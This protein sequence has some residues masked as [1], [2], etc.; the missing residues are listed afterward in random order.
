M[1]LGTQAHSDLI[2]M[3][4][5]GDWATHD[6]EHELSGIYD[7]PHGAGLAVMFPAWM[8]F[9]LN[10]DL[11]RFCQL[12]VRVWNLEMDHKNPKK[13]ALEGI[14]KLQGF[15]ASC[16]LATSLEKL[17]IH[18][19]R[20]AEMAE[21]ATGKGK[22]KLGNFVKLEQKDVVSIYE[23]ASEKGASLGAAR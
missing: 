23:L 16:G 5:V 21:K 11:D 20:Y 18:D 2:G 9:N 7:V 6:I 8:K 3:G 22:R 15:W 13:T 12:A 10:H 14:A 19:N 1:W 17:G 4:R